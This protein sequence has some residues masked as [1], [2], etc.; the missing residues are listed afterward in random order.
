MRARKRIGGALPST[1]ARAEPALDTVGA[2][3]ELVHAVIEGDE[4]HTDAE[5]SGGT[6]RCSGV[7]GDDMRHIQLDNRLWYTVDAI[8]LALKVDPGTL[9]GESEAKRSARAAFGIEQVTKMQHVALFGHRRPISFCSLV[10]AEKAVVAALDAQLKALA[11]LRERRRAMRPP[12]AFITKPS[13]EP[14]IIPAGASTFLQSMF[15][16]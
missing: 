3:G 4:D 15:E 8:E 14:V 9:R 11:S 12:T 10:A 7:G 2:V 1:L 13:G 16:A 5:H 6:Q